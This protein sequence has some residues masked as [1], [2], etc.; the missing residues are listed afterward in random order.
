MR[1]LPL[2]M[3]A[4]GL[5]AFASFVSP[6]SISAGRDAAASLGIA[7]AGTLGWWILR[8][9]RNSI[10]SPH[11]GVYWYLAAVACLILGLTTVLAMHVLPAQYAALRRFH[12]HMNTLGFIGITA[13]GTLQVLLPTAAGRADSGAALRLRQD[14]KWVVGGTLLIA[15]GAGWEKSLV[16][17]G[18]ILWMA[19]LL[20]LAMAW[21]TLYRNELM[22][23]NGAAVS[24]AGALV[25]LFAALAQGGGHAIGYLPAANASVAY[26][27]M[28]LLPLITG[29]AGYLLPLWL[30]PSAGPAWHMQARGALGRF[31]AMRTVLFVGAGALTG[32]WGLHWGSL[33]AA[34]GI[35]LFAIQL[36]VLVQR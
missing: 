28:F 18:L 8:R 12:L 26:V 29:A 3:L 13:I 32:W 27:L 21:W 11:P 24:L 33:P 23:W 31:S 15:A 25:G 6:Q 19:P 34:I 9:S 36:R 1:L 4:A 17:P 35:G 30:R 14:V 10:G 7:A 20:R 16:W 2:G 5:V 22:R